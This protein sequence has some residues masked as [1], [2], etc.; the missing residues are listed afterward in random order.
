MSVDHTVPGDGEPSAPVRRH[1]RALRIAYLMSRFPTPTE[2][3]ILYEILELEKLG[4]RIS[5]HPLI[6]ERATIVHPGAEHLMSRVVPFRPASRAVIRSQL[7]WLRRRPRAYLAAWWT[8][9]RGTIRSPK[10]L[11]RSLVVVPFGAHVARTVERTGVDHIHAHW[12]THPALGALVATRLTGRPYSFTAHAHDI[13]VNRSM[14]EQKVREAA[15]VV[16]ISD[17]NRRYLRDR[18]GPIVDERV[19][20]IHCGADPSVFGASAP[21]PDAEGVGDGPEGPRLRLL[22]VA[23]LQPQKGHRVLLD[24]MAILR[25]RGVDVAARFVGE[26]DE[27]PAIEAAIARL[28]LSER[29]SLLGAVPRGRVAQELA[30]SDV[31]AQPSIILASG[32]T[33]GIPVA[34]MEALAAERAV[35]ASNLSGIPEL[36]RDGATGL[37]VPP[38]DAEALAAAIERLA[39]EPGLRRRLGRAGRELVLAEF[40]LRVNAAQLAARITAAH[41]RDRPSRPEPA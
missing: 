3:F 8:A 33:E 24:A 31:V 35:V 25:S 7:Y 12:A 14:L 11:L 41:G 15:F 9:I 19:T 22:V 30:R 27:R 32:K 6:V 16:T 20:V 28:D 37:L 10:F 13:F 17:F 38:G 23:S 40:D 29:V 34:L 36:V 1:G 4:Y 18:V 5:I 39:H 21:S 26:G 2:T